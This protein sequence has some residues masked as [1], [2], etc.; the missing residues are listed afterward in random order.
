M[1]TFSCTFH[2]QSVTTRTKKN[3][4]LVLNC[5]WQPR[6]HSLLNNWFIR[7]M[8]KL[9]SGPWGWISL[10]PQLIQLQTVNACL[11]VLVESRKSHI[12]PLLCVN[13]PN[14]FLVFRLRPP[15]PPAAP[16]QNLT[17]LG[18]IGSTRSSAWTII[19]T[20]SSRLVVVLLRL[21]LVLQSC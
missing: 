15:V 3:S 17:Q 4:H 10:N 20:H 14:N 6:E 19:Q 16:Q 11:S 21:G 8:K 7:K 12:S 9:R 5:L 13:I 1:K 2:S 18:K